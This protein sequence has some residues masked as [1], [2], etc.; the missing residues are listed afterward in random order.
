MIF[1]SRSIIVFTLAGVWHCQFTAFLNPYDFKITVEIKPE[2]WNAFNCLHFTT[3]NTFN[4]SAILPQIDHRT[5]PKKVILFTQKDATF[6][7]TTRSRNAIAIKVNSKLYALFH[8]GFNRFYP[9]MF[10]SLHQSMRPGD[11]SYFFELRQQRKSK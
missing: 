6:D 9:F 2:K 1:L 8:T 7:T 5:E 4:I 10:V 11:V 3:F